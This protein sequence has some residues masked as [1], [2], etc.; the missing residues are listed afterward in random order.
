L[1]RNDRGRRFQDLSPRAGKYFLKPVVA[2]GS[3]VADYDRD[4]RSDLAVQHLHGPA[5]LLQGTG[6]G[7]GHWLALELIGTQSNRDG[8]GA[9]VSVTVGDRILVRLRQAGCSYLSCDEARLLIGLGPERR[10]NRVTV[11]WPGGRRESW[12][13]LAAGT[14]VRLREGTGAPEE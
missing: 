14:F 2:R 6:T 12:D 8:V 7:G 3:A 10:A 1:F 4:G 11:R 13:S 9:V 5:A